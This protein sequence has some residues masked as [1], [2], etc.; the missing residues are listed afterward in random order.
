M[1]VTVPVGVRDR[2][3]EG[4]RTRVDIVGIHHDDVLFVLPESGTRNRQRMHHL[5]TLS[6][7]LSSQGQ[8][9]IPQS[10]QKTW[11]STPPE[12]PKVLLLDLGYSFA[13]APPAVAD[14]VYARLRRPSRAGL[15]E[16][17]SRVRDASGFEPKS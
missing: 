3:L 14:R 7:T 15:T 2:W 6:M 16:A 10:V 12:Q 1:L 11:W 5:E 13:V 8:I 4:I 17:V 9:S